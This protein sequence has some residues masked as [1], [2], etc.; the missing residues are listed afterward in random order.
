MQLYHNNNQNAL[1]LVPIVPWF[2]YG[3]WVLHPSCYLGTVWKQE[4]VSIL[5]RIGRNGTKRFNCGETFQLVLCF[6]ACVSETALDW[7]RWIS[8]FSRTMATVFI[9]IILFRCNKLKYVVFN[10]LVVTKSFE[11]FKA[12]FYLYDFYE[13][14][15]LLEPE[16][17]LPV[18]WFRKV[19][20]IYHTKCFLRESR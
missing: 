18:K 10:L 8:V 19:I 9:L 4:T 3:W 14:H 7:F 16:S 11:F 12:Y 13:K 17:S 15:F 1:T 6:F 20:L 5:T 2:C